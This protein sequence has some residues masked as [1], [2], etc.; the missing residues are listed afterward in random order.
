MAAQLRYL[1]ASLCPEM[2][3]ARA[4][5][6]F[7]GPAARTTGCTLGVGAAASGPP[8]FPRFAYH[9]RLPVR[10][11]DSQGVDER[12]LLFHTVF[13]CPW[14]RADPESSSFTFDIG[15]SGGTAPRGIPRPNES[16][17]WV[18]CSCID[19]LTPIHVG[20]V[21]CLPDSSGSDWTFPF[22]VQP[23]LYC[24][25]WARHGLFG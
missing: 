6:E 21:I 20:I 18:E 11:S 1:E 24:S 9:V 7:R 14:V 23:R 16:C 5:V 8:R 25:W 13:I 10:I 15:C 2:C 12:L 4:G 19:R 3:G 22:S 17:G